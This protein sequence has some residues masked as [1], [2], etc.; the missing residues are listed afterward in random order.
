MVSHRLVTAGV[1]GVDEAYGVFPRCQ[2]AL[3][4]IS[5]RYFVCGG[6]DFLFMKPQKT[7]W[8]FPDPVEAAPVDGL[9]R[10][11]AALLARRGIEADEMFLRPRLADL[12][13]PAD[14][15]GMDRVVERIF[16][17]VDRGEKVCL[18]GD[19]DVDGVTSVALLHI[20]LSAYGLVPAIFLPHRME[21]GYGLS[22][23]GIEN[24]IEEHGPELL[25]AVDCGT[26]A[27]AEAGMLKEAGVDLLILDH[28][29]ASPDGLPE[30][31]AMVNPKLAGLH[32]YL[33]SVGVVFKVAHALLRAR[34]L[35]REVFDLRRHLDLVALGTVADIVPLEGE[36]RLLV[37]H[38]V[39][40]LARTTRPGLVALKRL[41]GLNGSLVA[42][43]I[44]F[45]LGPRLNA[46]GRLDTAGLS[47]ELLLTDD[48]ARAVE[49][50]DLLEQ[51]NRERQRVEQA[52]VEQ[53]MQMAVERVRAGDRVLVLAGE[54]WHPG[55]VGI[56]AARL[57]RH[58]HRP[59]VV[60]GYDEEGVGKGS[61]RSIEGVSMVEALDH[62]RDH[63]LR[64][65]GHA[66]AAGLSI[67]RDHVG[68][69]TD[70]MRGYVAGVLDEEGMVPV[71]RPD[72]VVAPH[73]VNQDLLDA[74]NL[75]APFGA[76]FPEPL[77]ASRRVRPLREPMLIKERHYK[78][79]FDDGG[80]GIDA[81]WF[82]GADHSPLPDPPW[83]LAFTVAAN[84]W[85]GVVRPQMRVRALRASPG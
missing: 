73:E 70:A 50:A 47:C 72:L 64:C 21:E 83:D 54:D 82:H 1:G 3:L 25:I 20:A 6:L 12:S 41:V 15:P 17:A 74:W 33:C 5:C 14:L 59:V 55:V 27:V 56:V 80:A 79:V 77:L 40:M 30:C 60:I 63:L 10:A 71:L 42:S 81:I 28:H 2:S 75:L 4:L 18:Y 23:K 68:A 31:V 16:E 29:E 45:R 13:D 49:L 46:A 26:T 57:M 66:M 11:A 34:P 8:L 24:C 84:E 37:R 43:D 69:F 61:A 67:H 62:C 76:G 52:I 44:G 78:F 36:N 58:F 65:G 38:G 51:H 35:E 22:R 85:R 48:P 32:A 53:A 19:Y 7:R 39:D 9:P